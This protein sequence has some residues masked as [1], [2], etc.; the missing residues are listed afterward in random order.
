MARMLLTEDDDGIREPLVRSLEREVHEVEAVIN[1]RD[2]AAHGV[3]GDHDLIVLDIGL[4]GIDGLEV[5]R[6]V[7]EVRPVVPII[8]LTA[9]DGEMNTITGL[10]AGADDYIAKP[11]RIAELLA[12][13]RARLRQTTTERLRIADFVVDTAAR[14]AW[15]GELELELSPK[16][17]DLLA[18]LVRDAGRVV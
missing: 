11:F 16:E 4:P 1:G 10:D 15:R 17:F 12:R 7:R 5:C 14:R 9:H 13:V 6:R 2:A 8:F 3:T 18:L